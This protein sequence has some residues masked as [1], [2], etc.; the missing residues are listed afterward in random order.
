MISADLHIHSIYSDG[1]FALP[2]LLTKARDNGYDFISVTDHDT[3]ALYEANPTPVF[4]PG[5]ITGVEI[6]A[7]LDSVELHVLGYRF[8]VFDT[9]LQSVLRSIRD[10]RSAW[11]EALLKPFGVSVDI[12][13]GKTIVKSD[14]VATLVSRK[15][16]ANTAAGY[17][18]LSAHR[19]AFPKISIRKAIDTIHSAGGLTFLAHPGI[20]VGNLDELVPTLLRAGLDGIE[21]F[22]PYC[23]RF[24]KRFPTQADEKKYID[25]IGT[26]ITKHGMLFSGGSDA[27]KQD[28]EAYS[29][30]SGYFASCFLQ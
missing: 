6:T 17:H 18:Y 10:D 21:R 15:I 14:I 22:Y 5:I 8:D 28:L 1:R 27:H 16:M 7:S 30:E 26:I 29:F 9:T 20:S 23:R 13:N 2:V 11:A 25:H 12:F 4:N 24:P 3:V 19:L